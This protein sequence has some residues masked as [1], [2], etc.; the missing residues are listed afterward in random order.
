MGAYCL[1][2]R[3]LDS[4]TGSSFTY[5][6]IPFNIEAMYLVPK[7]PADGFDFRGKSVN[8]QLKRGTSCGAILTNLLAQS[9]F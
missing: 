4:T 7:M 9:L 8:I 1:S 5:R 3:N 2:G 6:T